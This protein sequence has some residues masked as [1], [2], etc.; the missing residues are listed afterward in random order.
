MV[1]PD[2]YRGTWKDPTQSDVV[3]FIK[4]QTNWTKLKVDLEKVLSFAKKKGEKFSITTETS[5]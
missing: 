2:F 5:I 3:Q 1:M 4:D